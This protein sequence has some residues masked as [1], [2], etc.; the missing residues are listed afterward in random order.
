MFESES[1]PRTPRPQTHRPV[2]RPRPG[3]RPVS[4]QRPRSRGSTRKTQ[5]W[6]WVTCISSHRADHTSPG[7]VPASRAAAQVAQIGEGALN[8]VV[9]GA[10]PVQQ[11]T[12]E[13]EEK[14]VLGGNVQRRAKDPFGAN[15]LPVDDGVQ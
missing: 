12:K 11:R 4:P 15:P 8:E 6:A 9:A 2:A 10:G 5:R 3:A 1:A 7:L 14:N 13:H